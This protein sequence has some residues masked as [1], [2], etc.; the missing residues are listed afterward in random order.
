MVALALS[1]V[2]PASVRPPRSQ[3]LPR[4]WLHPVRAPEALYR[5]GRGAAWPALRSPAACAAADG[6]A[7]RA[8]LRRGTW[9]GKAGAHLR[10]AGGPRAAP[11]GGYHRPGQPPAPQTPRK[12]TR[13]KKREGSPCLGA[14]SRPAAAPVALTGG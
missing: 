14:T 13:R 8:R 9:P 11:A 5:G 4:R 1:P 10:G 6:A 12:R 3:P 2:P 7:S